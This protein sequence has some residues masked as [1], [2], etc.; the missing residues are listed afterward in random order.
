MPSSPACRRW[1]I[2]CSTSASPPRK[3]TTCATCRNSPASPGLLRLPPRLPLHRRSVRRSR[4]HPAVR[5]RAG[6]HRTR[7]HHRSADS[8]N[9]PALRRH[10]SNPDRHQ[11]RALCHRRRR[12]PRRGVRHPPRA[13]SRSRRAGSARRL[14]RRLR[15]HQQHPRRIPLRHPGDG[16][17]RALLGD[18][19]S[20]R[21][22]SL[23]QTAACAGRIHRAAA[24]HLRHPRRRAPR[25]ET[26]RPAV[27]RPAG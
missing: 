1:S 16:H 6:A 17:R 5:R 11:G 4:R 25:R 26:G 2:T 20:L 12:T 23:P 22:G 18:V 13:H 7:A 3:S 9:L 19:L 10:L 27:G 8:G 15:R 21:D 14:H 24:R